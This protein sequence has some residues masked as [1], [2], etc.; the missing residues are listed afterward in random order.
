VPDAPDLEAIR[1]RTQQA[2]PG[3]W[4]VQDERLVSQH[5]SCTTDL[6]SAEDGLSWR[7][8]AD[9][10]FVAAAR[11]DIPALIE[12]ISRLQRLRE[13]LEDIVALPVEAF[14]EGGDVAV[15][16]QQIAERALSR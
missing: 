9:P 8:A 6:V 13:A 2:S 3:P 11:S 5:P 16:A 12:E 10:L 14:T 4:A 7:N 15:A 1:Q